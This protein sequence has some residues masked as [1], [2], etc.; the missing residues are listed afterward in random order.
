MPRTLPE[1]TGSRIDATT[2]ASAVLMTDTS[3]AGP[4]VSARPT[5]SR[6][7]TKSDL[8]SGVSA[9][10]TGSRRTGIVA[11]SLPAGRSTTETALPNRLQT[12]SVRPSPLR[13]GAMGVWPR[14]TGRSPAVPSGSDTTTSL[15][16]GP[17]R[18]T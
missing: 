16:A 14:R 10:A 2:F 6:L 17:S 8:P 4:S 13:T 12:Y 11:A 9:A 15:P 1:P 7:A 5:G 18:V 3:A